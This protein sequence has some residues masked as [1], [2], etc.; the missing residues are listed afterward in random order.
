MLMMDS[1][2]RV[3]MAQR[4]VGLAIGEPPTSKGYTPSVFAFLPRLLE[5]AGNFRKGSITGMYTVLVESDDMN[6]P[7]AD[8]VRSILDGHIVL[9]RKLAA[10][11]HYPAIDV[12]QSISRVMIDVVSD[13]HNRDANRLKEILSVY[14]E[15]EDLLNIGAYVKGSN[16]QID[17]AVA[18]IERVRQYQKQDFTASSNVTA[19]GLE[20]AQLLAPGSEGRG[21]VEQHGQREEVDGR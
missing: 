20:L 9:S 8:T 10:A 3:A 19:A 17:Y 1:L 12:L 16:P 5:R 7:V 13:S 6:D 2:T 18:M 11:G 21:A 4:E 15:A 14:H